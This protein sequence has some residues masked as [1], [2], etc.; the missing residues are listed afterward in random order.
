MIFFH[1]DKEGF[2]QYVKAFDRDINPRCTE[3]NDERIFGYTELSAAFFA[4]VDGYR[5]E[6]YEVWYYADSL[7]I[8]K[9]TLFSFVCKP[10]AYGSDTIVLIREDTAFLLEY[11][12]RQVVLSR[13]EEHF[14][15]MTTAGIL[16]TAV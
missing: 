5:V 2:F 11:L 15:V 12:C 10:V 9:F 3:G 1:E 6:V 7:L 4:V 16:A 8:E 14:A 13:F